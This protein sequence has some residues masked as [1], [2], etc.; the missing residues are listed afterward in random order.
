MK[1]KYILL[2]SILL[3]ISGFFYFRNINVGKDIT[4]SDNAGVVSQ[5]KVD[6]IINFGDG[7][8]KN[9]NLTTEPN[10]SAFSILKTTAEKEKINLQVKQ[11]DFG[12]FVEKIGELESTAKKSWIYY[13]NGESGQVAADTMELK[14][15]DK[16]EWKYEVPKL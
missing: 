16:V 15:G 8:V 12:V 14:N 2:V 3:L 11:Y 10:D 6:L 5:S 13:V 1:N 4:N 9:Y 7:N